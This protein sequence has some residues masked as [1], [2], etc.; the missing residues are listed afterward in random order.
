MNGRVYAINREQALIAIETELHGFTIV[1][2]I[3]D[4]DVE[5]G[6]EFS[7]DFEL[8][9]GTQTLSNVSANRTIEVTVR[10]HMVSRGA[11]RQFMQPL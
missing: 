11:V 3:G 1:E 8:D 7:W 5:M 4:A 10:S 9:T 6:D 2:L